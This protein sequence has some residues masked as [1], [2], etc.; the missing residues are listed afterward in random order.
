MI[1]P[2]EENK[3]GG[4]VVIGTLRRYEGWEKQGKNKEKGA[5]RREIEKFKTKILVGNEINLNE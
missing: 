4:R 5:K 3:K 2:R 1:F